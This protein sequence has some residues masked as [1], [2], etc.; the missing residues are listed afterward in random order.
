MHLFC[1]SASDEP[2]GVTAGS[3]Q[4]KWLKQRLGESNAPWKLVYG[5][6]APYS[7]GRDGG[8]GFLRWPYAQWGASAVISGHVHNYE[9]LLVDDIPYFV[10]GLGGNQ[11]YQTVK[12]NPKSLFR[13]TAMHGAMRISGNSKRI[14]FEFINIRNQIT[15]RHQLVQPGFWTTINNV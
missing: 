6:R 8:N 11:I 15:D 12:P 13:Y 9:R 4:A 7:S 1:I 2:D 10:N 5:H 14:V 3:V